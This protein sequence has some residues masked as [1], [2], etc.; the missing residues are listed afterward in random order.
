MSSVSVFPNRLRVK[1]GETT[2]PDREA[3]VRKLQTITQAEYNQLLAI[4]KHIVPRQCCDPADALSHGLLIA[5][6]KYEG[7]GKLTTYVPKC[8]WYYALQQLKKRRHRVSFSDLQSESDF[9]D[10]LDQALPYLEDPRYVEAVD[11]P[12]IR[13]IEEILDG[14]YDHRFRFSTRQAIANAHRILALLRDNANLGHGIGIDEYESAPCVSEPQKGQPTYNNRLVRR[15]VV[16]HLG[17]ELHID[18]RAVYSALKALR[19]STHQALREGWLP[20]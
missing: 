20:S 10:Y 2:L 12:F 19:I 1:R 9:A 13:R 14:M 4:V 11:E 3:R 6:R 16:R 8:A 18:R 15:E 17:E 5:L 7:L